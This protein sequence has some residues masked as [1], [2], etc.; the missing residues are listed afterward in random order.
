MVKLFHLAV[1]YKHPSKAV[2]LC[3]TSD[4]TS[5]G[6]FQRKSVEEFMNFT[7]QILV[8]RSQPSTRTS[9]KEQAYMCHIY[10]RGDNLAGALISDHEY[11]HRVAHTLLNKVLEDFCSKIPSTAWSG[12]PNSV[13]F[14]GVEKY[15]LDYQDP[16]S[17]DS[18]TRIQDELAETQ[19]ILHNTLESV[20]QR[21]EKLDD[22]VVKSEQLSFQSKT[23][24][25]TARKTNACCTI[26]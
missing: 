5:F 20:L 15:L 16:R 14:I 22:L 9:V 8:E 11:P 17:A 24:Y 12:E 1:L 3:A 25:K 23:F 10:V 13:A 21:G 6:Y 4:L 2:C 19:I 18:L 26:L 7:S